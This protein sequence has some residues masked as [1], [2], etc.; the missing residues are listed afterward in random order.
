[1]AYNGATRTGHVARWRLTPLLC[2]NHVG[3]FG[4]RLQAPIIGA[5]SCF[6]GFR[7]LL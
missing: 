7:A 5:A 2:K 3:S 6:A 4:K 1:M